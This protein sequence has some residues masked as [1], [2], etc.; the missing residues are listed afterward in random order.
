[1]Y[2]HLLVLYILFY[3]LKFDDKRLHFE[4]NIK[5]K[6][7]H[8]NNKYNFLILFQCFNVKL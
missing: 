6:L 7:F 2:L 8:R 5:V 1:M 3:E 4:Y